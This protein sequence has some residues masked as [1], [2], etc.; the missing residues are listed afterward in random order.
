MRDVRSVVAVVLVACMAQSARSDEP[1]GQTQTEREA[2]FAKMLTGASLQGFFTLTGKQTEGQPKL[3]GERYD[4]IEVRK[5]D[6]KHWLFKARIRYGE[7]DVTLPLT[8]P[9][10]WAGDTAVVVVDKVG[11]PGLGTYSARVLFHDDHYAG[12]WSGAD[13]GGHLFGTIE[14]KTNDK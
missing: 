5:I 3:H 8:L 11:F 2:A 12:Q 13:Y 10:K 9:V 4:L 1:E 6:E 7:N 14:R